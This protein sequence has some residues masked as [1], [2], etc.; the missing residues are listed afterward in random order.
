MFGYA[1]ACYAWMRGEPAPEPAWARYLDANPRGYLKQG[2]R[3]LRQQDGATLMA[4]FGR[5]ATD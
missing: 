5:P 1:L 4:R 3:Y 2:T